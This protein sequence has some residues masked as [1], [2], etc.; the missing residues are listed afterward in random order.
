MLETSS[1][2][3]ERAAIE[4]QTPTVAEVREA[5]PA[6]AKNLLARDAVS[7]SLAPL[8]GRLYFIATRRDGVRTRMD[9]QGGEAKLSAADA[10]A[11]AGRLSGGASGVTAEFI[12]KEDA[13]Y[14]SHQSEIARLPAYRIVLNDKA[15]TRYYVDPLSGALWSKVDAG[16]KAYRW[17][18]EGLHRLDMIPALRTRPAWDIMMLIVMFGV[19]LVC[20]TGAYLGVRRIM[21]G[22][23]SRSEPR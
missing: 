23:L 18:H 19:T 7:L 2:A 6:L 15:R 4:G 16:G 14:F 3:R 17:W 21:R 10:A 22:S 1:A 20:V 5:V 9:A 8:D 12:T 13:Y 11:I